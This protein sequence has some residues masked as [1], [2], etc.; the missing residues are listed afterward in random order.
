MCGIPLSFSAFEEGGITKLD[1][2]GLHPAG[3]RYEEIIEAIWENRDRE[4]NTRCLV[5]RFRRIEKEMSARTPGYDRGGAR[6]PTC[7]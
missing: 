3:F 4:Y 7:I 1:G 2:A 5:K 6:P